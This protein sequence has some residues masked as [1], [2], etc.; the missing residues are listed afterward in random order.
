MLPKYRTTADKLFELLF[1]L[2]N[3]LPDDHFRKLSDSMV[4]RCNAKKNVCDNSSKFWSVGK[5]DL[6]G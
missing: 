3:E 4:R 1:D 5:L 2:W 6:I